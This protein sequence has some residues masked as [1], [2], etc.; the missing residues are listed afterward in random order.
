[1]AAAR[2]LKDPSNKTW[3]RSKRGGGNITPSKDLPWATQIKEQQARQEERKKGNQEATENLK[4]V[5]GEKYSAGVKLVETVVF[6]PTT[7][8]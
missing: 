2:R 7:P 4:T 8:N 6:V 1:M 5:G 3:F